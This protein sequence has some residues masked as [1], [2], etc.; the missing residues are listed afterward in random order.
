M[1][2]KIVNEKI[3]LGKDIIHFIDWWYGMRTCQIIII[4]DTNSVSDQ[5]KNKNTVNCSK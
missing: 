2:E 5:N 1:N 3:N 4:W